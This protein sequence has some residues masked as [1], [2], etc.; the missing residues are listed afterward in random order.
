MITLWSE[1]DWVMI[2]CLG[3]HS[4]QKGTKPQMLIK[5]FLSWDKAGEYKP[6]LQRWWQNTEDHLFQRRS[7]AL[8]PGGYI[9]KMTTITINHLF[10]LFDVVEIFLPMMKMIDLSPCPTS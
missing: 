8:W 2:S 3:D 1:D 10:L 5:L 6:S 4:I 9:V 7:S